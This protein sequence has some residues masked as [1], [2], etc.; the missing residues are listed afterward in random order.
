[1]D[2]APEHDAYLWGSPAIACAE[3]VGQGFCERG[4]ETEPGD[5]LEVDDLPGYVPVGAGEGPMQACAESFLSE[6]AAEALLRRGMMP[7]VSLRNRNAARLVRFQSI[8]DPP[9]PLA[10][11]WGRGATRR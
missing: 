9:A 4:W 11:P 7:I 3:L 2:P 8:A 5:C 10:G 1:M 6:R